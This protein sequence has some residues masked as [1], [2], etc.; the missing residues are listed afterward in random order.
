MY[1]EKANITKNISRSKPR[2]SFHQYLMESAANTAQ[3]TIDHL[4]RFRSCRLSRRFP[5]MCDLYIDGNW[6]RG[7]GPNGSLRCVNA[8]DLGR[9]GRSPF[10][11]GQTIGFSAQV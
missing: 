6:N 10:F 4:T 5:I 9:N 8:H 11:A 1:T 7:T 2:E 3:S